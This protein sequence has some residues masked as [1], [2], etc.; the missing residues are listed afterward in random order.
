M[1]KYTLFKFLYLI[2]SVCIYVFFSFEF[3]TMLSWT[4][5]SASCVGF[6][7]WIYKSYVYNYLLT[8]SKQSM[9]FKTVINVSNYWIKLC[10]DNNK[11]KNEIVYKWYIVLVKHT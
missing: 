7:R 1:K 3:S 5:L 10:C 6:K 4:G 11:Y 9:I 8:I 2:L